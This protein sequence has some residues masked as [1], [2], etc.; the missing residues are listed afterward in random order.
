MPITQNVPPP[1]NLPAN[2]PRSATGLPSFSALALPELVSRI[3]QLPVT[4]Q[5][6]LQNQLI[7]Q[8]RPSTGLPSF[9]LLGLPELVSGLQQL[10]QHKHS[11]VIPTNPTSIDSN[12][13]NNLAI[14][15][16]LLIVSNILN[17][18]LPTD[19][20][21]AKSKEIPCVEQNHSHFSQG[22]VVLPNSNFVGS[23]S[24]AESNAAPAFRPSRNSMA[25]MS[26]YEALGTSLGSSYSDSLLSQYETTNPRQDFQSPYSMIADT[27]LFSI[28]DLFS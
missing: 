12:L 13:L 2:Q 3:Q 22:P 25:L 18:P 17:A 5:A 9:S 4:Q 26:P 7:N 27:D 15:L 8:V 23:S 14:A 28:S 24:F 19:S 20:S 10:P 11:E 6:A 21:V 16:Q 1:P